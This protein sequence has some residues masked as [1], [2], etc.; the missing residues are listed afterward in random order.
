MKQFI[1]NK[2]LSKIGY[3][4]HVER[5]ISLNLCAKL[6]KFQTKDELLAML[7]HIKENPREYLQDE[8]WAPLALK[9]V[10]EA[11]EKPFRVFELDDAPKPF[12]IY[13][14]KNIE[15]SAVRQMEM[16]MRLPVAVQGAL[17]PDAHT[18]YGLPIGGVLA[19]ENAVIPYA[20][21]VDIGCRMALSVFDIS[22]RN[23]H[24][25]AFAF[26][27]A[28][29][30]FT[31]FGMEGG[32]DIKQE[33]EVLDRVEFR[34]TEFLRRLHGKA[35]RQLGSSG[36]GNHFVEFGLL[37]LCIENTLG[38]PQGTYVALLSHSGS[39]GLGANIAQHYTQRAMDTCK[40][41]REIQH[42]AWLDLATE[43]G[44]EYWNG[45][46]LAG[47]YARACH[48]QIHHNLAKALGLKSLAKV[49]NHHNFAWQETLPDGKTYVV[50]RKGAT[51]AHEN[52]LGIIPGSMTGAG[53][54]VS[55][56]GRA[57]A[58]CSASHGAGRALSR[59]KAKESMT[60]SA[61][62]KMLGEAGITLIGGTTE[63]NP[64]AY[65]NIEQV[66]QAQQELVKIE[67]KFLPKIVR[68]NKE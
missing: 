24:K 34:E 2:D 18:G 45:M 30:E 15:T 37:D 38:L 49:E 56:Q 68:M 52:E 59:K 12:A 40:L 65:K 1:R 29:K 54:L 64:N 7:T 9:M 19:T 51:P 46:Q 42:L 63:E 44:Q 6:G 11:G 23:F 26:K 67:G 27:T 33:H 62:K 21:G 35:I 17:M 3:T 61:M 5:S 55:G 60:A 50:H 48:D 22:E 28:L 47:D 16:A 31:H 4:D 20:V 43:D 41:P 53:Y 39:R 10:P 8:V 36:S 14:K 58:L 13:G 32:L 57:E 25:N 66:M